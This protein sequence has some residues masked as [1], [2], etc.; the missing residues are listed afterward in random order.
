MQEHVDAWSDREMAAL[1]EYIA[2]FHPS[3]EDPS[4]VWLTSKNDEF[5]GKCAD[6][7]NC[8]NIDKKQT[9]K[10]NLKY[11]IYQNYC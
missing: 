1:V 10:L 8:Y 3:N 4:S 9:G 6:A 5:L 7:V 2:R 11:Q